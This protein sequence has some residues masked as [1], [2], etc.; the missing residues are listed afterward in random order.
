MVC[1]S[2]ARCAWLPGWLAGWPPDRPTDRPTKRPSVCLS[3]CLS[4][5]PSD[6]S[7]V[8]LLSFRMAEEVEVE[9]TQGALAAGGGAEKGSLKDARR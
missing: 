3:V 9:G 5:R 8:W 4:V 1:P 7:A 2:F 6:R